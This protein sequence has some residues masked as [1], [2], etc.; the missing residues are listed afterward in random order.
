MGKRG[1]APAPTPLK[2]LKGTRLDRVNLEEPQPGDKKPEIPSWLSRRARTIW[3]SLAPDLERVGVLTHWDA[4]AF[5]RYC[6]LTIRL[7]EAVKALDDEGTVVTVYAADE[8]G[9]LRPI[10]SQRNP[11]VGVWQAMAAEHNRLAARFGL[12]PS[13]RSQIRLGHGKPKDGGSDLLS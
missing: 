13:D 3:R 8:E 7:R 6:D 12:T 11:R 10:R 9:V 2:V 4:E 5:A 1:F